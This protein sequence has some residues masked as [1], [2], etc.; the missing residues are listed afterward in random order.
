MNVTWFAIIAIMLPLLLVAVL[1]LGDRMVQLMHVSQRARLALAIPFAL[2]SIAL[3]VADVRHG[4]VPWVHVITAAFWIWYVL[5]A[6]RT[7]Q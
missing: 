5:I 6:R 7:Q 4:S 1:L 2:L 3:A